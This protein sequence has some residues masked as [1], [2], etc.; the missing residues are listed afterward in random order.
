MATRAYGCFCNVKSALSTER[1]ATLVSLP[2]LG[3]VQ[4]EPLFAQ[5]RV[6]DRHEQAA[7]ALVRLAAAPKTVQFESITCEIPTNSHAIK[8]GTLIIAAMY[9]NANPILA[10]PE[11]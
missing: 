3:A 1:K 10:V 2:V 6:W 9:K 11:G 4:L 8:V 5:G 7:S